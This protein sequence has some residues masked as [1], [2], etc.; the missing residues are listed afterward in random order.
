MCACLTQVMAT[1]ELYRRSTIGMCLIGLLDKMVSSGALSPELAI[2]V[3]VLFD[4]VLCCDI[5]CFFLQLWPCSP[6]DWNIILVCAV[7]DGGIGKPRAEQGY[8]QGACFGNKVVIFHAT[9][10]FACSVN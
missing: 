6:S 4:K 9:S 10:V 8:C 3:L 7:Y 2:Q 1:L 5:N